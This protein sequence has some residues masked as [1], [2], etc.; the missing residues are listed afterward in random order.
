MFPIFAVDGAVE[1]EV[2]E[3][4][5]ATASPK[6]MYDYTEGAIVRNEWAKALALLEPLDTLLNGLQLGAPVGPIEGHMA[7]KND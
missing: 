6:Q 4:L 5:W 2:I 7:P 1:A 3:K